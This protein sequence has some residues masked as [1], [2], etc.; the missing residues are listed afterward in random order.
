MTVAIN[1]TTQNL[2]PPRAAIAVSGM[3]I[4]D[5]LDIYRIVSGARTPVRGGHLDAVTDTGY[6]VV[7]AEQPFD[8]PVS[9]VAVINGMTEYLS[10]GVTYSLPDAQPVLTDAITG[11]AAEI[12]ISAADDRVYTRDAA[13]FRVGGRNLVVGSDFGQ[14][15]GRYEL[16]F[17]TTVGREN[18]MAL[19]ESATEGIMLLRAAQQQYEDVD[20][21]I[22]VDSF[23]VTRYSQDGSDPRR[24][25]TID[26]AEVDSW[27]DALI[28]IG[29]T[30]GEVETF[31]SGIDY[32][33]A[34]LDFATYLDA[35]QGD[36]S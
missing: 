6:F 12:K 33:T 2:Y 32:G 15:E 35:V 23:S 27:S 30:Y 24:L 34:A 20:A 18:L 17:E 28:A 8:V 13:R 19:L 31:Y 9:Y 26:Y 3:T 7:D 25:V 36:F 14:A 16:L 4:G 22:S 1:V 21:Y 5:Q 29:F 11:L 10:P